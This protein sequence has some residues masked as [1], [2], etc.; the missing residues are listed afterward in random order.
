M[1]RKDEGGGHVRSEEPGDGKQESFEDE[2]ERTR[3]LILERRNRFMAAALAGIGMAAGQ[4]CT[5][6]SV[7]LSVLAPEAGT[8]GNAGT[9]SQEPCP[10]RPGKVPPCV[11]L[12]APF[13]GNIAPPQGGNTTTMHPP[14]AATGGGGNSGVGA[15]GGA[16]GNSGAG[17]NGGAGGTKVDQCPRGGPPPCVCLTAPIDEDAGVEFEP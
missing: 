8:N 2:L 6:A 10:G 12:T 16:G 17:G 4:A 14:V 5:R 15:N 13:G 1:T 9:I 3:K 11:C 7:C